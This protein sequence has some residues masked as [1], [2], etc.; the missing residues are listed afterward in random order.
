MESRLYGNP[1]NVEGSVSSTQSDAQYGRQARFDAD[2]ARGLAGYKQNQKNSFIDAVVNSDLDTAERLVNTELRKGG[3]SLI[4]IDD[5]NQLF[6]IKR[7][8]IAKMMDQGNMY[9][10][11]SNG[12]GLAGGMR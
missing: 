12:T 10:V 11:P 3:A 6:D 8:Q 2:M 9:N 5:A 1:Q 4:N 7:Q